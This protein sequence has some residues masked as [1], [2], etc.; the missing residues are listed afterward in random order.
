[1]AGAGPVSGA[2]VSDP[3][4]GLVV[5]DHGSRRSEAN[6][7]HV[8]FIRSWP[9]DPRYVAVEPAHMELAEPSI[10]RAFDACVAA[11]ATT[12]V[13]A[14]YFLGPGSHWDRD[15]PALAGEA[16]ARHPGVHYLVAA[17]LGP[18]PLLRAVVDQRVEHCLAHLSGAAPEC[19]ACAGSGRCRLR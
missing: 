7:Q 18:H 14:P 8:R 11:G 2:A 1:M 9:P 6:D 3:V 4:I 16:A 5:A 13:V 12:V 10:A 15:L 17:P 19:E